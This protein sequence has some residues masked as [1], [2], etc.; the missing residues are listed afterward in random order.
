MHAEQFVRA[1]AGL[2]WSTC[3][4]I[5]AHLVQCGYFAGLPADP[6][7]HVLHV[8]EMLEMTNAE[9]HPL[10]GTMERPDGTRVWKQEA[11]FTREDYEAIIAYYVQQALHCLQMAETIRTSQRH[12]N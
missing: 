2:E 3:D 12:T 7:A 10:F 9:D 11:A 5:C 8:Q 6:L 1:T 4:V